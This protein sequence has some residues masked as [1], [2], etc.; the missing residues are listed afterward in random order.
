MLVLFL[1]QIGNNW[2][3]WLPGSATDLYTEA[4]RLNGQRWLQDEHGIFVTEAL[5]LED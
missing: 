4:L 3:E 5:R 2:E 1:T